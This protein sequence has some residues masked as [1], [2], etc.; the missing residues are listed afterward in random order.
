MPLHRFGIAYPSIPSK[1]VN[2]EYCK[3]PVIRAAA[4]ILGWK[5]IE[6]SGDGT[7]YDILWSDRYAS[8]LGFSFTTY[9]CTSRAFLS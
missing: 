8:I 7:G 3:Y 1:Q 2:V 6:D 4:K 5:S 9:S